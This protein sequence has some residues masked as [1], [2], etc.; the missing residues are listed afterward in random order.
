MAKIT[1]IT[2]THN[3]EHDIERC[4][5]ALQWADERIVIDSYSTDNTI[6]KAEGLC[7][8]FIKREFSD[9]SSIRNFGIREAKGEWVLIIDA[10]EVVSKELADEIHKVIEKEDVD[11]Y[12]INRVNYMYGIKLSYDQPDYSIRLFK[13]TK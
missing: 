7:T 10:D 3:E 8:R 2:L 13:K 9:F 6:Q 12:Y 5:K 1:S 4:L 11:A